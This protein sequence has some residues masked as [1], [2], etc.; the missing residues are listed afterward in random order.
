MSNAL[1]DAKGAKYR[2]NEG[3][4]S[5]LATPD[6]GHAD[7]IDHPTPGRQDAVPGAAAPTPAGPQ[8]APRIIASNRSA[9][10]AFASGV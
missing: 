8:C 7:A 10:N 1:R 4:E 3:A 6:D 9:N 2:R 5:R